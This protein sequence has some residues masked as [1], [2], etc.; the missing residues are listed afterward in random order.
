MQLTPEQQKVAAAFLVVMKRALMNG[1]DA[2]ALV[3][4]KLAFNNSA[5]RSLLNRLSKG[6]AML[7]LAPFGRNAPSKMLDS[8][9]LLAEQCAAA[10]C[11]PLAV[12]TWSAQCDTNWKRVSDRAACMSGCNS[13]T[14]WQTALQKRSTSA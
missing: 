12:L 4:T 6:A 8:L 1:G 10:G 14:L 13:W 3:G 2:A 5:M 9:T 11:Q 7:S